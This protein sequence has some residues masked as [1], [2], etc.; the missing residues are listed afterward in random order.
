[1]I[2]SLIL[3]ISSTSNKRESVHKKK[4][5]KTAQ[6]HK[7]QQQ[8]SPVAIFIRMF[9][10]R[11]VKKRIPFL[12]IW[13]V[14]NI[15]LHTIQFFFYIYVTYKITLFSQAANLLAGI[16]GE[17]GRWSRRLKNLRRQQFFL[18][19]LV[20]F[21][22]SLTE[23]CEIFFF[24]SFFYHH[25]WSQSWQIYVYNLFEIRCVSSWTRRHSLWMCVFSALVDKFSLLSFS[26]EFSQ[27][28]KNKNI[29]FFYS[30]F[31]PKFMTL[32]LMGDERKRAEKK[33]KKIA[34][35]KI[36]IKTFFFLLLALHLNFNQK[37]K[38]IRDLLHNPQI[39][40]T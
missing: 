22:A 30:F 39:F 19:L 16:M 34:K 32:R 27:K 3:P 25:V 21:F 33:D 4:R 37:K 6:Y 20:F 38:S 15:A 23:L 9:K 13:N 36:G 26:I 5:V 14:H 8:F 10:W 1:M 35:R 17:G 29:Y 31:S 18:F 11:V 7:Q 12:T 2:P 24:L 40:I 28:R